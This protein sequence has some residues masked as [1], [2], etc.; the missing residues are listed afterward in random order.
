M[1]PRPLIQLLAVGAICLG[2]SV[3]AWATTEEQLLDLSAYAGA[4]DYADGTTL[5]DESVSGRYYVGLQGTTTY[6]RRR[7][8]RT[9]TASLGGAVRFFPTSRQFMPIDRSAALGVEAR[10]SERTSLRATQTVQYSPYQQFGPAILDPGDVGELPVYNPDGAATVGK[11]F[12]GFGTAAE[13]SRT[14]GRRTGLSL[15]YSSRVSVAATASANP[16]SQRAGISFRHPLGRYTALKL[17]TAYR[18]GRTGYTSTALPTRAQD[19]DIGIDY[20]RAL[21]FSRST[22]LSFNSGTALVSRSATET[23]P[24]EV[25]RQLVAIGAVTAT[26]ALGRRWQAELGVDRNLQYVDGFPDPFYA[27]RVTA[28]MTGQIRRR[29]TLEAQADYSTGGGI[30]TDVLAQNF[31]G[32]RGLARLTHG[33]GRRWQLFAAYYLTENRLSAEALSNLPAGVV[34]RPNQTSLQVG[35]TFRVD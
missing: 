2:S 31:E 25:G 3:D 15:H 28:R 4:G 8:E 6:T 7:P 17:G 30:G 10:L 16:F 5:L 22:T 1:T 29:S 13:L 32:L 23:E 24:G 19:F 26:Q 33:L 21:S 12:Y 18:F 34:L 9:F 14:F 35:F 11:A 20:N 27:T